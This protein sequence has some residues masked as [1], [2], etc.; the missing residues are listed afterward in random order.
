MHIPHLYLDVENDNLVLREATGEDSQI[1]IID[2][3]SMIQ[4]VSNK[5]YI[6]YSKEKKY[7][8]KF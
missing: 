7:G 4:N 2:S 5:K 8:K 6:S 1:W 3:K